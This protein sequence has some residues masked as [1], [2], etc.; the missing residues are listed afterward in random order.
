[1]VPWDFCVIYKNKINNNDFASKTQKA[2][3]LTK[4]AFSKAF[5]GLTWW[6]R[7]NYRPSMS[8][9]YSTTCLHLESN[10]GL[11]G[12]EQETYVLSRPCTC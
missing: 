4:N 8:D 10:L 12:V 2:R 3:R 7:P 1:M 5:G 11:R 9:H 6:K